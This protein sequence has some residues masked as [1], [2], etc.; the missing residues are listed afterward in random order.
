M[1]GSDTARVIVNANNQK[2]W[3]WDSAPF[4]DTAANEQPTVGLA[5]FTFN[6]RFPGQQYDRETGTH[7]NYFRDYEAG[8]GRYLQSDPIGLE[9]ED[10]S[11][12]RY[13]NSD[14]L[15]VFDLTAEKGKGKGTKAKNKNKNKCSV[16]KKLYLTR[17]RKSTKERLGV[18]T[19]C[20]ICGL[21]FD[22]LRPPTYGHTP[23]PLVD[24]HNA[25]GYNTDQATRNNYYNILITQYECDPCQKAQGGKLKL[26]SYRTDAG[27]NFKPRGVK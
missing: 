16:R 25:F 26:T 14:V 1:T 19:K 23:M 5:S 10:L 15:G 20:A 12:Y 27:P 2:V 6:L 13:A 11:N 17:A 22:S 9:S 3:L 7:Y 8:T 21:P 18:P 24:Y 4:G